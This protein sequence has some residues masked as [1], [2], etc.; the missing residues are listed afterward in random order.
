MQRRNMK[1]GT[2]RTRA[3]ALA[4]VLASATAQE[5]DTDPSSI[6]TA[7]LGF[8]RL[9]GGLVAVAGV[10]P[11]AGG[12]HL[13]RA[14]SGT[15]F[16]ESVRI[17][18]DGPGTAGKRRIVEYGRG[19]SAYIREIAVARRTSDEELVV[20][21]I[22]GQGGA[23]LDLWVSGSHLVRTRS[24]AAPFDA[25][26][27]SG[28]GWLPIPDRAGARTEFS[29]LGGLTLENDGAEV[30][31]Y[32]SGRKR[33]DRMMSYVFEVPVADILFDAPDGRII[34]R[35]SGPRLDRDASGRLWMLTRAT[36]E[37][38]ATPAALQL[39]RRDI[40][41]AWSAVPSPFAGLKASPD[42]DMAVGDGWLY[43]SAWHYPNYQRG[44]LR[45]GEPVE[46]GLWSLELASGDWSRVTLPEG[47]GPER[48]EKRSRSVRLFGSGGSSTPGLTGPVMVYAK[49]AGEF[50]GTHL[51]DLQRVPVD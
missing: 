32:V 39:S 9:D 38:L 49:V 7:G 37:G 42:Y 30:V 17:G 25:A 26:M 20:A 43:V 35:G 24:I 15:L 2:R 31:M 48:P 34:T 6:R 23:Y 33:M 45:L 44:N 18:Q 29:T 10:A 50:E 51:G 5:Q 13:G 22:G 47:F 16:L 46:L 4:L 1:A 3:T 41:G 36:L 28:E 11:D 27:F 8:A 21:Q 19:G 40:D 12:E 14:A